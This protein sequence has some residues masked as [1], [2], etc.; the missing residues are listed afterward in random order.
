LIVGPNSIINANIK[1]QNLQCF[2]KIIGNITIKEEAYLHDC[3]Q[4]SGDLKVPVLT[5][6]KG[7]IINGK[8]S[9][10]KS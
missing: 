1:A 3:A 7:C 10:K 9:M 2:G 6:E 4:L 8:I 5:M